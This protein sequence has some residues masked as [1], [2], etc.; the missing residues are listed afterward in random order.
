MILR[1]FKFQKQRIEKYEGLKTG[2]IQTDLFFYYSYLYRQ[3]VL[4]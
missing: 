4:I 3:S 2:K 1:Y